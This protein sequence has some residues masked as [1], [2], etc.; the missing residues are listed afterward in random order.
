MF[1]GGLEVGVG[2]FGLGVGWVDGGLRD[3]RHF[4]HLS[5]MI[6]AN[7]FAPFARIG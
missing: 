1:L 4:R 3:T 6:R 2:A 5:G 7:R